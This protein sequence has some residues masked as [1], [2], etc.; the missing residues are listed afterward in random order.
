MK[1]PAKIPKLKDG[2]DAKAAEQIG[3]MFH[4]AQIGMRRIIALGIFAWELK[5]GQ[6]KHGEFG[7]WLAVHRPELA[8]PHSK[9]GKPMASRA[10]QGHMAVTKGV[11]KDAGYDTVKKFLNFAKSANDADLTSGR[12]LLIEEK[13]VS[14]EL[15]PLREKICA[16]VDGKT[17]KQLNLEYVNIEDDEDSEEGTG[18]RRGKGQLPGS[19]GLTKEMREAAEARKEQNRIDELEIEV[20]EITKRLEQIA[21]AMH[22]GMMETKLLKKFTDAA[23]GASG[24]AKRT[25]EA[26][27]G[28]QS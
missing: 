7:A 10:L 5:L 14:D 22:L 20:K 13:K 2:Q 6:L 26:R 16:M 3:S 19:K 23:D 18:K 25:I 4:D 11:L 28:G 17:A 9:T 27:K 15:K 12:F 1:L 21:D 24:F 8:T